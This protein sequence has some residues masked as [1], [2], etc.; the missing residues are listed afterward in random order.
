MLLLDTN[1]F[2]EIE[3]DTVISRQLQSRIEASDEPAVISIVTAE[4]SMGG[5]LARLRGNQAREQLLIAY[6][7]FARGLETLENWT[8]L[9]WVTPA[10]DAFDALRAQRVRIGTLDLRIASIAIA[11]DAMLLSRNLRDFQLVPG[12]RVE[13]WLD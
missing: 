3:R 6:R 1:H 7:D 12:L 5:W 13:N 2:S 9:D 4:E 8:I 10:A 11:H